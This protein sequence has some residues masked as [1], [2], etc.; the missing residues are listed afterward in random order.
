[1]A[2]YV[3]GFLLP[4][5]LEHLE[6]YRQVVTVVAE[7]WKEHG[8]IDYAEFVGDDLQSDGVRSFV[9]GANATKDEIVI[10]GWVTFAS[11]EARDLANEKVATD[12]R[13]LEL[14]DPLTQTVPPVF[15]PKRMCYGGFRSLF[16]G[17]G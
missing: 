15:D 9:D 8:A 1:M 14:V 2:N 7:I 13:I 10:F 16:S 4:V 5:P 12:P 3:D 11:R 17:G 6:T